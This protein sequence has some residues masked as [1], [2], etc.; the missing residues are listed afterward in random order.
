MNDLRDIL[1][2]ID[3]EEI[4]LSKALEIL[5]EKSQKAEKRAF[6]N[7]WALRMNRKGSEVVECYQQWKQG[8]KNFQHS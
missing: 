3:K 5:N 1:N 2:S 8:D 6:E 7:G 4:S